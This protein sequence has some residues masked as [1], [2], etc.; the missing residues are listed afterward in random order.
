MIDREDLVFATCYQLAELIS[1]DWDNQPVEIKQALAALEPTDE[2]GET[3]FGVPLSGTNPLQL[4]LSEK[5]PE[6]IQRRRK[7]VELTAVAN[8]FKVIMKHSDEW[9]TKDSD[10]I[11]LEV[12]ARIANYERDVKTLTTP[13]PFTCHIT[14]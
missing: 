9:V 5:E 4:T 6:S 14:V 12:A 1:T 10:T 8:I 13:V 11:K 2:P 3:L 7:L